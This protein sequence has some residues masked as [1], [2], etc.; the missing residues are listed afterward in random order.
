[1]WPFYTTEKKL[2]LLVHWQLENLIRS[3]H[4]LTISDG[5]TRL[6]MLRARVVVVVTVLFVVLIGEFFPHFLISLLAMSLFCFVTWLKCSL[7]ATSNESCFIST[8]HLILSL[9]SYFYMSIFDTLWILPLI[10]RFSPEFQNVWVFL[11]KKW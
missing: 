5:E 3:D 10:Y 6:V 11:K 2:K 1:M 4:S 8:K 7:L 9:R